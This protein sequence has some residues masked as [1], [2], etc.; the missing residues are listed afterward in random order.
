MKY[1]Y[2]LLI[3]VGLGFTAQAQ[4]LPKFQAGLKVG[5]NFSKLDTERPLDSENKAG[6]LGG[7]WFRFGAAGLHFQPEIYYTSKK[8]T[9]KSIA[10][11]EENQVT[12]NSI[13]VPLL[14]GTKIGAMG[15]GLRFNTGPV[16]SF[17]ID[18]NQSISQATTNITRFDAKN[19]SFAW[20]FGTGVDLKSLSLDLRY[21]LGISKLNQ[22]G[23]SEAKLNLFQLAL[24]YKF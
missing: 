12:F 23:Y 5:A 4:I 20:Q 16:V 19:Q 13:D 8:T 6:M 21:E 18:E 11:A 7:L 2:T 15:A 1:L 3:V 17:I 24:G 14:V 9:L 10:T 22:D